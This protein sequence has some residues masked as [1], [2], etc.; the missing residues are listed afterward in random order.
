MFTSIDHD[1]FTNLLILQGQFTMWFTLNFEG[2]SQEEIDFRVNKCELWNSTV[3]QAKRV[4]QEY[5]ELKEGHE[6][7]TH[8][9]WWMHNRFHD[10]GHDLEA[11]LKKN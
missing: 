10:F 11:G 8:K 5:S 9:T 1:Y 7:I 3:F 4:I 2:E 6:I